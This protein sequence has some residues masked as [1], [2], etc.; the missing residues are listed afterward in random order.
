[1]SAPGSASLGPPGPPAPRRGGN[2]TPALPSAPRRVYCLRCVKWLGTVPDHVC[3]RRPIAPA[4]TAAPR[5]GLPI[6]PRFR[7]VVAKI[8]ADAVKPGGNGNR[9]HALVAQTHVAALPGLPTA[10]RI[11]AKNALVI[12]AA[13]LGSRVEKHN[14]RMK[15]ESGDRKWLSL[16]EESL[17]ARLDSLE[18]AY[19]TAIGPPPPP[20]RIR[21][22]QPPAFL[23]D[24]DLDNEED[25]G[26]D[27]DGDGGG[28]G[29]GAGA[30][31]VGAGGS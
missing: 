9:T 30:A 31:G 24:N 29:D 21:H 3:S 12:A 23:D 7:T 26:G 17:L 15:K 25:D 14:Q 19:R 1:M 8:Q 11:P 16:V 13:T 5:M 27:D 18:S 4:A 10:R 28:D 2:V 6:P 22:G 20:S